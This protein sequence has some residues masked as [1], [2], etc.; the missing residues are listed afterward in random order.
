MN[1]MAVDIKRIT[2]RKFSHGWTYA[3]VHKRYRLLKR[4][5]KINGWECE[6]TFKAFMDGLVYFKCR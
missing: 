6:R 5:T 2:R 4:N 3:K 1:K